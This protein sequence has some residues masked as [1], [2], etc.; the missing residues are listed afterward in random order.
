[1]AG[2]YHLPG[3]KGSVSHAGGCH[4]IDY[5]RSFQRSRF[6]DVSGKLRSKSLRIDLPRH[7]FTYLSQGGKWAVSVLLKLLMVFRTVD[8]AVY[9][10]RDSFIVEG[11]I[12]PSC[13]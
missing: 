12:N 2:G 3:N 11:N 10:L 9:I 1:M 8:R 6:E 7:A 5:G 13:L 4:I